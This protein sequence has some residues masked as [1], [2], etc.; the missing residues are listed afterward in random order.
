MYNIYTIFLCDA[1]MKC[2]RQNPQILQNTLPRNF[3]IKKNVKIA[4]ASFRDCSPVQVFDAYV[5][6][7]RSEYD[8]TKN[9]NSIVLQWISCLSAVSK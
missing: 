3:N 8:S 7:L 6:I 9:R 5:Q 4:S 1:H 2:K